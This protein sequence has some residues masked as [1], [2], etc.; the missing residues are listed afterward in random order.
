MPHKQQ[1]MCTRKH[2]GRFFP[3]SLL[4]ELKSMN[5]GTSFINQTQGEGFR[6]TMGTNIARYK[7]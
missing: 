5:E 3:C 2:M 1:A 7:F 4:T 6:S